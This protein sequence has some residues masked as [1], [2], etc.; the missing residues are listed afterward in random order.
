MLKASIVVDNRP[1][2]TTQVG[3]EAAFRAEPVAEPDIREKLLRASV[4]AQWT[5]PAAYR[6]ALG[7]ARAYY[8]ELLPAIGMKQEG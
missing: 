6:A 8:A 2:G 4:V 1:G 7:K 5:A 3:T